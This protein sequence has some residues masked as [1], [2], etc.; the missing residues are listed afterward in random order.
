[1]PHR[2]AVAI[3]DVTRHEISSGLIMALAKG[4]LHNQVCSE[5]YPSA[6]VVAMNQ[7]IAVS[8]SKRDFIAPTYSVSLTPQPEPSR[9]PTPG[10]RPFITTMP[11]L[12]LLKLSSTTPTHLASAVTLL[13]DPVHYVIALAIRLFS[14][15]TG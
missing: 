13:P 2:L 14:T 1:M 12:V 5:A 10:N 11:T 9:S 15:R 4:G 6:V 8:G 7:L 3:G